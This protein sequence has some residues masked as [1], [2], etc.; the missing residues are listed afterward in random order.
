MKAEIVVKRC[1]ASSFAKISATFF[2]KTA[3]SGKPLDS[4]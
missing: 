2:L 1:R 3:F 4:N